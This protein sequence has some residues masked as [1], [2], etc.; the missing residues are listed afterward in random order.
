MNKST[1]ANFEHHTVINAQRL[2]DKQV[3][4][5]RA[6]G[7]II[8][9]RPDNLVMVNAQKAMYRQQATLSAEAV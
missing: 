6:Q 5:I 9:H 4:E 8:K 1:L 2:T 7:L 3:S